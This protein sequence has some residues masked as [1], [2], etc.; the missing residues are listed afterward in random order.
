MGSGHTDERFGKC[1]V[2]HHSQRELWR[3]ATRVTDRRWSAGRRDAAVWCGRAS[4]G[5]VAESDTDSDSDPDPDAHSGPHAISLANS[6]AA[7]VANAAALPDASASDT[8]AA[9][10]G[11]RNYTVGRDRRRN[12]RL[13]DVAFRARVAN[14]VH[15]ADND[16]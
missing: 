4:T 12:R 15:D 10:T 3:G 7:A 1:A 16:V 6:N 8:A 5:A 11:A 2:A 14:C 9:D 13:P